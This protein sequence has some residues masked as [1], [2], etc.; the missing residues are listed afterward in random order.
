MIEAKSLIHE[1]TIIVGI[2]NGKQNAY[3]SK[4]YLDELAFLA[5]TAG[6]AVLKRFVQKTQIPSPKTFIGS[7]NMD[8]VCFNIV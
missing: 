2:I 6:G 1:K 8:E 3:Q 4:E 7:G 5:H